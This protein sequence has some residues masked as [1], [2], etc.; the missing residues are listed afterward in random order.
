MHKK[1]ERIKQNFKIIFKNKFNKY[2]Q[3]M[4]YSQKNIKYS[5]SGI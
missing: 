2:E 3:E 5:L 1:I 4:N